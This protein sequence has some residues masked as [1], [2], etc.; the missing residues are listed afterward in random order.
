MK[1]SRFNF[2]KWT[3]DGNK[4]NMPWVIAWRLLMLPVY[5]ATLLL[6]CIVAFLSDGDFQDAKRIFNE[7][8]PSL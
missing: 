1:L 7:Y 3:L 8:C 6:F 5:T 2:R 4:M